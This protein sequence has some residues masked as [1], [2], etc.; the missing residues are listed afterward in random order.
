MLLL[1]LAG[2]LSFSTEAGI[3]ADYTTQR[4]AVAN[5]DTVNWNWLEEDTL[6][7]ESEG[8][9]GLAFRLALDTAST[10]FD[11]N[12]AASVSTRSV[13]DV[14]G[15]GLEQALG[16]TLV[17]RAG[18]DADLRHYHRWLPALS[19]TLYGGRDYWSNSTRLEL[20]WR[21]VP[22]ARLAL[23]DGFDLVRYA[24]PDSWYHDY[25][26]N[27]A[28]LTGR[29]EPG[30]FTGADVAGVWS[31]RRAGQDPDRDYDDWSAQA[32][33]EH[34]LEGGLRL[35]GDGEFRRREYRGSLAAYRERA[36][37]ATA[38]MDL[39]AGSVELAEEARWT[40]YD[41]ATPVYTS[42]FENG[43]RLT[44]DFPIGTV[45][46]LRGGPRVD[47]GVGL[48]G[49]GDEDYRELSLAAGV[50]LY[51]VERLWLS[52]EDRF[53]LR[54]YPHADT[55]WQSDYRF[56]EL[57]LFGSWTALSGRQGEL[58]V[59]AMASVTPEWH[60][61]RSDNI[62]LGVYS[63]ELKYAGRRAGATRPTEP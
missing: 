44:F 23:S 30:L 27:R 34:R 1:F 53:G 43:A 9:A 48:D 39:G 7:V 54:R 16:P 37:T 42:L 35:G 19:E 32:G 4:Y 63:I 45:L 56:N 52:V 3:G 57:S 46:T 22:Y 41:S 10:R 33:L 61:R 26:V 13:R 50:D 8:R 2:A 31:R 21:P 58:R 60:S 40:V 6:D 20:R 15:L 29:W 24:R 62:A 11:A 17:L 51:R 59:E 14:L 36:V 25:A 5:Y 55:A 49:P 18:N 47:L 28:R 38:G 12:N